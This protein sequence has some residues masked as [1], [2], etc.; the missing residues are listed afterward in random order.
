MIKVEL[1]I[2]NGSKI[3][4]V[5]YDSSTNY[6]EYS[7]NSAYDLYLL[8]NNKSS[9]QKKLYNHEQRQK[10]NNNQLISY[11]SLNPSN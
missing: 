8:E 3:E 11:V 7:F 10:S 1:L 9:A 6:S 2:L 4:K 5:S